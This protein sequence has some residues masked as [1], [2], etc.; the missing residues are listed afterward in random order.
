M[1]AMTTRNDKEQN[2]LVR[3]ADSLT[4]DIMKASD[5]EILAEFRETGGDPAVHAVEMRRFV[6]RAI[7]TANKGRLAAAK[8]RI[9]TERKPLRPVSMLVDIAEARRRLRSIGKIPNVQHPVTLAARN[10]TELSD[11]DVL[12]MYEDMVELGVLPT[13]DSKDSK[14]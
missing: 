14:I 4:N 8:A 1:E 5:E 12:T 13:D 9:A 3:L 10:E 6:D 11:A 7:I 2:P